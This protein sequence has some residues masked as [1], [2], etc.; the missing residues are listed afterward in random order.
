VDSLVEASNGDL[1]VGTHAGVVLIPRS[2]LNQFDPAQ[3]TYYQLGPGASDEAES[4]YQ[5]RD[6]V[7]W[8]GDHP[9]SLSAR[10]WQIRV[11]YIRIVSQPDR[12]IAGWSP[13]VNSLD[14]DSSSG[15]VTRSSN[16]QV[17][18]PAWGV[19]DDQIINV[20]QDRTGTM[21]YCTETGIVRRGPPPFSP[22]LQPYQVFPNEGI[23]KPM[24][25][26]KVVFGLFSGIGLYRAIADRLET[27]ASDIRAR[28]FYAAKDGELWVGTNG[29]RPH[30][31]QAPCRTHVHKRRR[32][33]QRHRDGRFYRATMAKFGLAAIADCLFF[34]GRALSRFIEKRTVS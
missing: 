10:V 32:T 30:S 33:A 25:T 6:G 2:A 34:E 31:A 17:W 15:T 18:R 26:R 9:W 13:A 16:I 27:P 14:E 8:V 7:I 4:L 24:K 5:T 3:L 1:W 28:S 29:K 11:G 22:R 21:W 12:G 19:H 23:S 20:F